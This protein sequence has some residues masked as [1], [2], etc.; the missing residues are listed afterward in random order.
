MNILS[1]TQESSI[2]VNFDSSHHSSEPVLAPRAIEYASIVCIDLVVCQK[3]N[4]GAGFEI[5]FGS[6]VGK[7]STAGALLFVSQVIT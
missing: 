3:R 4:H 6:R 5:F 2:L 7:K 1:T